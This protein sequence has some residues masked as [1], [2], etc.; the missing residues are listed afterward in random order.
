MGVTPKEHGPQPLLV[1]RQ[2]SGA[3]ICCCRLRTG[4][5][6]VPL[7]QV[8]RK[9]V[10]VL[11]RYATDHWLAASLAASANRSMGNGW[12]QAINTER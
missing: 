2:S 5:G 4:V 1:P 7:L 8:H 11:G 3:G 6:W 12:I 10:L 9:R